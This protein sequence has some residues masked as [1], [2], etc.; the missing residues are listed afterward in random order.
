VQ[1]SNEEASHEQNTP[2]NKYDTR[3]LEAS[4]LARGQSRQV[5]ELERAIQDFQTLS[6]APW[7]A[8]EPIDLGALLF[9]KSGREEDVYLLGPK[10]G[11]VE[12][13]CDGTTVTVITPQS[14]LGRLLVG[15]VKGETIVFPSAREER[16][17]KIVK[18]L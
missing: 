17:L 1:S 12:V 16:R 4:Y 3:A 2:E 14:P 18:V 15:K 11:G 10:G 13:V 8:A 5:V 6:P 9:L 7:Q